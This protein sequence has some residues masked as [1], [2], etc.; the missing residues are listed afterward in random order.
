MVDANMLTEIWAH[1]FTYLRT[2]YYN[3]VWKVFYM[4]ENLKVTELFLNNPVYIVK[5]EIQA[6]Y[7]QKV[8]FSE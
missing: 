5:E 3:T 4:S 7:I 8:V 2:I 1:I 6:L